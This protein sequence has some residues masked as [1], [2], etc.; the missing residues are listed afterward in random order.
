MTEIRIEPY[1]GDRTDLRGL[2]EL[3]EDSPAQLDSY[4]RAGR[5]LVAVRGGPLAT[6]AD[7]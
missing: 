3:A 5:V 2:F 1:Q 6:G 4:L 7:R